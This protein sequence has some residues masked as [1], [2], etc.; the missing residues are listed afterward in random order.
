MVSSDRARYHFFFQVETKGILYSCF[1]ISKKFMMKIQ[2]AVDAFW[3]WVKSNI[4]KRVYFP[5][6]TR[7]F[8]WNYKT[9]L[10]NN[11]RFTIEYSLVF[12]S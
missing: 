10:L 12:T 11:T 5:R 7:F 2:M 1:G 6:R 4:E 8:F 3:I 9:V